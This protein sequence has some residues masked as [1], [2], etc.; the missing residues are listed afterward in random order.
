MYVTNN[1]RKMHGLPLWRKSNQKKRFYS[2]CPAEEAVSAFL[3]YC[4]N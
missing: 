1:A 4:E 2:R 3:Y